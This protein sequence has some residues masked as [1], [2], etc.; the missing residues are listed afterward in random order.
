MQAWR[1]IF[2]EEE[3]EWGDFL[4]QT[5]AHHANVRTGTGFPDSM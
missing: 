4:H 2:K 3:E 5:N 1:V